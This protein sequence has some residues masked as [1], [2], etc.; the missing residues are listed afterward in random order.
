MKAVRERYVVWMETKLE[1][2]Q[3]F[4]ELGFVDVATE[5]GTWAFLEANGPPNRPPKTEVLEQAWKLLERRTGLP[6]ALPL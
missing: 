6:Q 3:S 1:F 4:N 5:S 2:A